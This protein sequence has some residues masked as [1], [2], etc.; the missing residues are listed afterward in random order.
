MVLMYCQ[1]KE[2]PVG[3]VKR[4]QMITSNALHLR[5]VT[6]SITEEHKAGSRGC[7]ELGKH[8]AFPISACQQLDAHQV[9][10]SLLPRGEIQANKVLLSLPLT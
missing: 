3:R 10:R 8:L 1:Y 7:E 4:G 2:A 5:H 9:L 6:D